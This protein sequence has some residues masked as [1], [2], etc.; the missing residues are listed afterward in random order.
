MKQ[1]FGDAHQDMMAN[2]TTTT[3]VGYHNANAAKNATAN[4]YFRGHAEALVN[5]ASAT[6]SN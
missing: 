5:L 3:G 6:E 2:P 4:D 1:E